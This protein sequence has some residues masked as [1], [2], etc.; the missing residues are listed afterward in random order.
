MFPTGFEPANPAR[1]RLQTHAL[2]HAGTE[3]YTPHDA[4][5]IKRI[6]YA[7]GDLT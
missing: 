5:G 7:Y 3:I 6:P 1:E 2:D 4:W